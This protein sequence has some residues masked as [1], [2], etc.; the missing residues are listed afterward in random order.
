MDS[1]R[2]ELV[3]GLIQSFLKKNL[4][5]DGFSRSS[6]GTEAKRVGTTRIESFIGRRPLRHRDDSAR[7]SGHKEESYAWHRQRN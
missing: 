2:P 4:R 7:M 6:A 3:E 5:E 1:V